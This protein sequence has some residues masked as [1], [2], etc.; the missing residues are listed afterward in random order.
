MSIIRVE[1]T[2]DYTIMCNYHFR[3]KDMSLKAKGL[4]SLMLS[5]PDDWDYSINGLCKIC[6]ENKTAITS[7]LG[8]LRKFGYLQVVKKKPNE[9]NSGRIEYEYIITEQKQDIEKQDIEKQDIEKQDIEN[10]CLEIL[11]LENQPQYNT[12]NK[13]PY[14]EKTNNKKLN[15]NIVVF[16]MQDKE[17][18]DFWNSKKIIEHKNLTDDIVKAIRSC[19][20]TNRLTTEDIKIAIDRYATM[21]NDTSYKLC[22]YRWSL[23]KFLKQSNAIT[24]F[25][26]NGSKWV[27]YQQGDSRTQMINRLMEEFANEDKQARSIFDVDDFR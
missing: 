4:L 8:E 20:K 11:G 26:D 14:R 2:K 23:V 27:N 1:K 13:I 18:F 3:E 24:E 7:T 15:N 5:L 17:I 9:T 6:K 21:L 10:L 25:L 19:K 12:N 22:S 16:D